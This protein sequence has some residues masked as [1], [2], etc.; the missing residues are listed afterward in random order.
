MQNSRKWYMYAGEKQ[1]VNVRAAVET[2][3]G[4]WVWYDITRGTQS[5][6]AM[7]SAPN[8]CQEENE[9]TVLF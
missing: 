4:T 3:I 8:T 7:I 6:F 2:H 5:N 9:G 1:Y